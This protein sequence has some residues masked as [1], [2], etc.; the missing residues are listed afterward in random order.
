MTVELFVPIVTVSEANV[1][2]HW[3]AKAKRAKSQRAA[4][5]W[6]C[7]LVC[8]PEPPVVVT[9][10]RESPRLLDTGDNLPISLKASR[11]AM[12]DALGLANDRDPRVEWKY[13][14]AKYKNK[15]VRIAVAAVR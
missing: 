12:A 9:L 15:G 14:Q 13:G 6:A 4:V 8:L 11:D 10:T 2:E 3:A 1:R 7:K 5:G